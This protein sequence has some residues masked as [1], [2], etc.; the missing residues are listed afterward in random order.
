MNRV[1]LY[2]KLTAKPELR[3]TGTG[4]NYARFSIAVNR[5]RIKDKE[6]ETDF[7]NCIAWRSTGEFI[8]KYFDKGQGIIV[9]GRIQI[10]SY[11]DKD[12][13]KR[14]TT[15]ILVEEVEFAGNKKLE[16]HRDPFEE[17]AND[18]NNF[19]E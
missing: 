12:G 18:E 1:I 10:G 6:Q 11:T 14:T 17:F 3:A 16:E 8:N 15:D 9:T 19:L 5:P 7:I 2:G 4:T 13:N